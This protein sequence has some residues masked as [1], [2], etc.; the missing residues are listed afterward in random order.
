MASIAKRFLANS[1]LGDLIIAAILGF[2]VAL[3]GCNSASS[4][5]V[6]AYDRQLGIGFNV[7]MGTPSGTP[8]TVEPSGPTT[9][10]A[11]A[12]TTGPA[13][14]AT[15]LKSPAATQPTQ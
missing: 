13:T 2:L 9:T 15:T 5:R 1:L 12:A 8:I 14:P 10:F 11:P 4:W 6:S 3:C 7:Q